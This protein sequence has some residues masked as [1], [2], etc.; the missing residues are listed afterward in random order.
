MIVAMTAMLRM[1][2]SG[3]VGGDTPCLSRQKAQNYKN[4]NQQQQFV[5]VY[6]HSISRYIL[7]H[8]VPCY[9]GPHLTYLP[10]GNLSHL[11]AAM[12]PCQRTALACCTHTR[13][14]P[15]SFHGPLSL[16]FAVLPLIRRP[17]LQH[18][19]CR[20]MQVWVWGVRRHFCHAVTHT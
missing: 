9:V 17:Q 16:H 20:C 6:T 10:Q 13:T 8:D 3:P 11:H 4:H 2:V 7:T 5:N 12:W 14:L 19:L 18:G 1:S 15:A